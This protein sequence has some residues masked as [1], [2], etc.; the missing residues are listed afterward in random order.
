MAEQ[1][2]EFPE[3]EA[4][5]ELYRPLKLEPQDRKIVIG[6][7]EYEILAE[8]PTDLFEME[9]SKITEMSPLRCV[10]ENVVPLLLDEMELHVLRSQIESKAIRP[11][12]VMKA[13][14][15]AVTKL[16]SIIEARTKSIQKKRRSLPK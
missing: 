16:A 2:V 8:V 14:S 9:A 3:D 4:L 10:T 5:D 6:D 1:S 12:E 13:F 15:P 7:E 11:I